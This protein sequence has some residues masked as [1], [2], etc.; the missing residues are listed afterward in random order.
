MG[1]TYKDIKAFWHSK[2]PIALEQFQEAIAHQTALVQELAVRSATLS[3][4]CHA[5]VKLDPFPAQ[6]ESLES[7]FYTARAGCADAMRHL[8][9]L[10]YWYAKAQAG[11][12]YDESA[13]G[14]AFSI[15][16]PLNESAAHINADDDTGADGQY[17]DPEEDE[18]EDIDDDFDSDDEDEDDDE[19]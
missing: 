2:E 4:E 10:V 14:K 13:K 18:D 16:H 3:G 5:K 11:T 12:L 19:G 6:G 9:K 8:S 15:P 17:G 1:L 7:Q